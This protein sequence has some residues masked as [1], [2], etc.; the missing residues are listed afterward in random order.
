[1][2]GKSHF[3]THCNWPDLC[4]KK[5][6][7][8]TIWSL[9]CL[10]ASVSPFKHKTNVGLITIYC[11]LKNLMMVALY[12][13]CWLNK[14]NWLQTLNVCSAS[15]HF[16]LMWRAESNS[17]INVPVLGQHLHSEVLSMHHFQGPIVSLCINRQVKTDEPFQRS[18]THKWF[19]S[20]PNGLGNDAIVYLI[21]QQAA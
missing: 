17:S 16:I 21:T 13:E 15:W 5:D 20:C 18:L 2:T 8:I 7:R 6:L 19:I 1:M 9:M 10:L 14:L 12:S 4:L 3:G 11:S